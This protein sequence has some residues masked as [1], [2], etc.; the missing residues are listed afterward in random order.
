MDPDGTCLP[1]F[2]GPTTLE[3][4]IFGA[5][6]KCT[7]PPSTA[8]DDAVSARQTLVPRLRVPYRTH[9]IGGAPCSVI[10]GLRESESIGH[11][12]TD[13]RHVVFRFS[14]S[15]PSWSPFA[16]SLSI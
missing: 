3:T 12:R 1:S 13:D 10:S 15:M 4:A 9:R 5:L 16:A 14:R 6:S 7:R 11:A 2:A 8:A